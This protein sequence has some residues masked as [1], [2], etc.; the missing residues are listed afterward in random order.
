MVNI[1]RLF[2]METTQSNSLENELK[3]MLSIK[4]KQGRSLD[5]FCKKYFDNYESERF[6]AVAIRVYYGKETII[7]LYAR[8]KARE[9]GTTHDLNRIPV[10]KF[11]KTTL[12]L[13]DLFEFVEEF[14]FTLNASNFT[15]DEMEVMNK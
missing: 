15:L 6:E 1:K 11:K 9:T 3:G 4:L 2:N 5:E 12:A 10:K 8:D 13:S 7:T 14:N